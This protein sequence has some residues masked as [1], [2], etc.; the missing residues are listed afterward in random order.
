MCY[1]YTRTDRLLN[2]LYY[3]VLDV[4]NFYNVIDNLTLDIYI[5][6]KLDLV[7]SLDITYFYLDYKGNAYDFKNV[8]AVL[9]RPRLF[10]VLLEQQL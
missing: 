3:G 2:N 4:G 1:G 9:G 5:N 10:S 7:D 8:F 6:V